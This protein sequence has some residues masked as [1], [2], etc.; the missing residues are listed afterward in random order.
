MRCTQRLKGGEG[1]AYHTD[2]RMREEHSRKGK[3][4]RVRPEG[5]GVTAK[6]AMTMT[7]QIQ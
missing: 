3:T 4:A 7:S 5:E 1:E 2:A 6:R